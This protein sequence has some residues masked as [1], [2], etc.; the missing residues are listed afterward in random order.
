MLLH[1]N[2]E[3]QSFKTVLFHTLQSIAL[4][5]FFND[6]CLE[7]L[8]PFVLVPP[9]LFSSCLRFDVGRFFGFWRFFTLKKVTLKSCCLKRTTA[10]HHLNYHMCFTVSWYR[11]ISECFNIKG[12][13]VMKKKWITVIW[14]SGFILQSSCFTLNKRLSCFVLVYFFLCISHYLTMLRALQS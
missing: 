6:V 12:K 5:S 2:F 10:P 11:C 3:L 4:V 8:K 1:W 7:C 9:Y 13:N 14:K